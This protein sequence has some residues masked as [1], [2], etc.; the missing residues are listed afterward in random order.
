VVAPPMEEETLKHWLME[1][2][3]LLRRAPKSFTL[4]DPFLKGTPV[5]FFL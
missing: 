1:V 3:R 2:Y 5:Y 4:C